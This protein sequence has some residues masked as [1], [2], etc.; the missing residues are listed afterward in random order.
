V[1][2]GADWPRACARGSY[3]RRVWLGL[4]WPRACARR[5]YG[6]LVGAGVRVGEAVDDVGDRLDVDGAL[7][8]AAG[9]EGVEEGGCRPPAFDSLGF[10]VVSDLLEDLDRGDGGLGESSLGA[11]AGD[12]ARV[13]DVGLD[14]GRGEEI[15]ESCGL[16]VEDV[17]DVGEAS[18]RDEEGADGLGFVVGEGRE[19]VE[20]VRHR[21][22]G[23]GAAGGCKGFRVH[24]RDVAHGGW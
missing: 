10:G 6:G 21:C 16:D 13:V 17:G 8:G 12:V 9:G 18:I 4:D 2:F 24:D 14:V 7:A 23:T 1:R 22:K 19:V 20:L 11:T 5:S 15:E 3:G